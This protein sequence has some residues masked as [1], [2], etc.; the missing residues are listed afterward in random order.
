M[1]DG[2][3]RSVTID[4][5]GMRRL[6][7]LHGGAGASEPCALLLGRVGDRSIVVED[8]VE[9]RNAHAAPEK[10]FSASRS[11]LI[12]TAHRAREEGRSVVGAWHGHGPRRA[13]LSDADRAGLLAAAVA[14]G[15]GGQPASVPFTY[16]V[17]GRGAGRNVVFRAFLAEGGAVREVSLRAARGR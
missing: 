6:L 8:L 1:E 15:S 14:P 3:L 9:T 17:S 16:L 4:P 12:E 10:A 5:A 13:D 11:A 7:S 2:V